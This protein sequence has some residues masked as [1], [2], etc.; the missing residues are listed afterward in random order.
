LGLSPSGSHDEVRRRTVWDDLQKPQC[1]RV[2]RADSTHAVP[3]PNLT[4]PL[5][6]KQRIDLSLK[7]AQI[8][9]KPTA[10]SPTQRN[11]PLIPDALSR[12]ARSRRGPST[13]DH[14]QPMRLR[15]SELLLMKHKSEHTARQHNAFG[16]SSSPVDS[17][18]RSCLLDSPHLPSRR[19]R[20]C[21]A[22]QGG[23]CIFRLAYSGTSGASRPASVCRPRGRLLRGMRR[24]WSFNLPLQ[25][26]VIRVVR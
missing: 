9:S 8:P 10:T 1:A 20:S 17:V 19:R 13:P 14:P 15:V 11:T 16:P 24:S 18:D 12:I 4:P 3:I 5:L 2:S 7:N 21:A 26:P 22:P 6:C 25:N 23:V